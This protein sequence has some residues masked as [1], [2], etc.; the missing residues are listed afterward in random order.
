[1]TGMTDNQLPASIDSERTIIGAILLDN[2]AYIE[3]SEKLEVDDFALDSHRHIFQRMTELME[4][5]RPVDIVTLAD[6]LT[7]HKEIESI[8]ACSSV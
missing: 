7:K 4:A 6:T 8:G 1:M 2:A 5:H 3:S